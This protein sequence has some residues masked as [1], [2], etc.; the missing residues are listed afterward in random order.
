VAILIGIEEN[1]A[2]LWNIFSNVSKHKTKLHING[3]RNNP[4]ALYNFHESLI[5]AFRAT[6]KEGVRSII[7]AS[8]A[9]SNFSKEF[10]NHICEHHRWLTQ[11]PN[12]AAF[13]TITGLA[14]TPSQ[15]AALMRAPTFHKLICKTTSEEAENLVEILEKRLNLSHN[16]GVVLFSLEEAENLILKRHHKDKPKPEYLLLTDGYLAD[17][18]EKNRLQRLMQIAANLKVK[19]RIITAESPGGKRLTQLGGFVCLV[20]SE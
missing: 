2:A 7:I 3:A 5:N 10:V 17:N 16:N 1:T 18:Q 14:G 6:L 11:G 8:P 19:T 13:S 4:S 9:R 20:Q 15:V 12:K